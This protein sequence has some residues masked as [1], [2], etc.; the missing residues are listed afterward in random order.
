MNLNSRADLIENQTVYDIVWGSNIRYLYENN[1][2]EI[3]D[4]R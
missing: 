4:N 3:N 2:S 1:W